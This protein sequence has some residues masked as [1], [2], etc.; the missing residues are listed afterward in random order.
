[1]K[2]NVNNFKKIKPRAESDS[3][4][5]SNG[6]TAL[7]LA[8]HGG[9]PPKRWYLLPT[10]KSRPMDTKATSMNRRAFTVLSEKN[11]A[12]KLPAM[13]PTPTM[14][15][16]IA[17]APVRCCSRRR[18]YRRDYRFFNSDNAISIAYTD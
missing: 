2:I 14:V 10:M 6:A 12:I 16:S 18:N 13:K 11:R 5:G 7:G 8:L 17:F 15:R 9:Y 1:M 3:A 4:G